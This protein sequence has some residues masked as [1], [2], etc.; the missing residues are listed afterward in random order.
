MDVFNVI[1]KMIEIIQRKVSSHRPKDH[2]NY[3]DVE[4]LSDIENFETYIEYLTEHEELVDQ[5]KDNLVKEIEANFKKSRAKHGMALVGM[6]EIISR[7]VIRL[8]NQRIDEDNERLKKIN[9][10]FKK[11]VKNLKKIKELLKHDRVKLDEVHNLLMDLPG[12][13]DNKKMFNSVIKDLWDVI[14]EY[15]AD[16]ELAYQEKQAEKLALKQKEEEE[17]LAA[18]TTEVK[19]KIIAMDNYEVVEYILQDN[20]DLLRVIL[21]NNKINHELSLDD[22]RDVVGW[23]FNTLNENDYS[24]IILSI[25]GAIDK[26]TSE[27]NLNE[28]AFYLN[29]MCNKYE[30]FKLHDELCRKSLAVCN[31]NGITE[32]EMNVI[33]EI[34]KELMFMSNSDIRDE[35]AYDVLDSFDNTLNDIVNKKKIVKTKDDNKILLK[36]FVLFDYKLDELGRIKPYITSDLDAK[37]PKSFVDVSIN[38]EKLV[39]NG[40]QDFNDLIDDIL[41]SGDP[42]ILTELTNDKI[43]RC[44]RPVYKT[45]NSH[46]MINTSY[47]NSTGM[48]R[49]RPRRTSLVRFIDE[50]VIIKP[51]S[52]NYKQI[53]E[54]IESKF[55]NVELDDTFNI[56]INY[57]TALKCKDT[58]SYITA[59]KRQDNS[60]LMKLLDDKELTQG[61]LNV[62]SDAIDASINAF[63]ELYDI[64]DNF[65][66]NSFDMIKEGETRK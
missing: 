55:K 66:F 20:I 35:K 10:D 57:L 11:C 6:D 28:L 21:D 15:T 34:Q 2:Y 64:N 23:S 44:V 45:T 24:S 61:E 65:K 37:N 8:A 7:A 54:L 42:R 51:D 56:Y 48:I 33:I 46:E 59:I 49:I 62:L 26:V 52:V 53:K 58:D 1:D 4:Y 22:I 41:L 25:L 14:N 17:K 43:D 5:E 30:L 32:D 47:K 29:A 9:R 50:K 31:V 39:S 40:Y 60:V 27:M 38:S 36:G 18:T 3:D 12:I 19:T 63:S 13:S 16:K